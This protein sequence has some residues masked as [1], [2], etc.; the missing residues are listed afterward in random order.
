MTNILT[1]IA[2]LLMTIFSVS[3]QASKLVSVK[4][5][6]KEHIMLSFKDG[7]VTFNENT[8]GPFAF[9][10]SARAE[11]NTFVPYGNPLNI[12][13]TS[14]I[15]NWIISSPDDSDFG[16]AGVYPEKVYRKSKLTCMAIK[17]WNQAKN[18][19]DFD[20]ASEHT[21]F[22][23]LPNPMQQGYSY[24]IEIDDNNNS[25]VNSK[26]ITY[27]IFNN[28]S[29]AV[30]VNIVGYS[31]RESIK[32][33]DLYMWL[34]DGGQRN[35]SSFEGNK[36]YINNIETGEKQEVGKLQ[37]WKKSASETSSNHKMIQSD[38]WN[39]DFSSVKTPG[40]Y[41]IVVEGI[42]CSDD[43]VIADDIYAEPTRVSTLGFFYMRI[44]QDNLYDMVPVPRRPLYIPGVS[45]SN[46]VVYITTMHP[47]HPEWSTFAGGDKWDRKDEWAKYVKPEKPT[48]PNAVGGHSDALDWD[49][50]LDHV[51]IIYDLLFPY[52]ITG[53]ILNDDNLGIPESGNG[54][55]DILDEARN[56]VD[57]W[58]SLRDG[59]GYSHGLNNPNSENVFYQ[60]GNTAIAAW[61]NAVN[62]AM[63][64]NCFLISGNNDL[65]ETYRDSA[66]AAYSYA[67]ELPDQMLNKSQGIGIGHM[68]GKDFK[69]T[70]AAYLYNLT[71]ETS[72]E[73]D[74]KSLSSCTSS[75]SKIQTNDFNQLYAV[76]AYLFSNQT[77]NYPELYNNMKLSVINEAKNN[78]AN[79]STIRPS[80]RA[81]DND[82]AHFINFLQV[83]R[84]IIAHA[85]SEPG[86]SD[87]TFFENALIL[88]ADWTLGRN[89]LNMILMTTAAT[90]L[91][92]KK[93]VP[94]AYTSGWNDGTPGVHPGHTPYMNINDWGGGIRGNPSWMTQKNYPDVSQWPYGEMYYNTRYVW[95]ANEFTPQQTMRGKQALYSYLY[96]LS[97]PQIMNEFK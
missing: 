31:T 65:M 86:S 81:T 28:K 4:V 14:D 70:S 40:K 83:Q 51:S 47:Y 53:G 44:G 96:A 35:Y 67:S 32:S 11:H 89:P 24:K 69:A 88:E 54:I 39:A 50:R 17:N 87:H 71:G 8:G 21:V 58:L 45:P 22:L 1:I 52:I 92:D 72:Y 6:D 79:Y 76:A 82:N 80:R 10:N 94:N 56:E 57:F 68:T 15:T 42:G 66:I 63:L 46:T 34:G 61:A 5:V 2:M 18:D 25:D 49:R 7:D 95:A 93:S 19:Y 59:K 73:D 29:E 33:A 60:A 74:L 41:R 91:E 48:N 64:A 9:T 90:G 97:K 3:L 30:R 78:E 37:F 26:T 85:I 12:S 43:F 62:A 55:P 27:D 84:T 23:R 77:I 20:W 75:S 36:V 38:V 13:G 16:E